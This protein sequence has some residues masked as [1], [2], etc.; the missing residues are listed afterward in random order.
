MT[1]LVMSSDN[2]QDTFE[3]FHYCLEKN[4]P[5]HPE[6][7]YSTETVINPYYKTI[8]RNYLLKH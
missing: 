6:V 2:N 5:N 4:W 3:L 1:I 8:C 7:I